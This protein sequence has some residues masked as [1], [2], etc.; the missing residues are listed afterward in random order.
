MAGISPLGTT[1][2]WPME[3]ILQ[4]TDESS[5]E[6]PNKKLALVFPKGKKTKHNTSENSKNKL[7]LVFPK[8]TALGKISRHVRRNTLE[9]PWKKMGGVPPRGPRPV[10]VDGVGW[11]VGTQKRKV[12]Q[13]K[14][15]TQKPPTSK[16]GLRG[17]AQ[18][19]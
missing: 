18:N 4:H 6:T 8:G 15:Q 13:E 11:E 9:S 1:H 19:W 3:E 2:W 12:A 10:G 5:G 7:A 16:P 14:V 17:G